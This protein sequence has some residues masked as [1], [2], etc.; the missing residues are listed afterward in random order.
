MN[1]PDLAAIIDEA[2]RLLNQSRYSDW[3]LRLVQIPGEPPFIRIAARNIRKDPDKFVVAEIAALYH[4]RNGYIKTISD[5]SE[6]YGMA[7]IAIE[8][9]DPYLFVGEEDDLPPLH[10]YNLF[11]PRYF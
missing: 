1:K 4:T 9:A 2:E 7:T 8:T 6:V 5:E 3:F 11:I 10:L